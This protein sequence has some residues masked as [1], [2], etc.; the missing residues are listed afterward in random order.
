MFA[1]EKGPRGKQY[2]PK[3]MKRIETYGLR[4]KLQSRGGKQVLWRKILK[5]P[6]GW[7]TMVPAP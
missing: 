4:T 5:G 3:V 1:H 2:K 7:T 6:T